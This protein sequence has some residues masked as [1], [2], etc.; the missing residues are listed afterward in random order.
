MW[1]LLIILV[2]SIILGSILDYFIQKFI[3]YRKKRG[4]NDR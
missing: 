2:L 1:S 4:K 3:E